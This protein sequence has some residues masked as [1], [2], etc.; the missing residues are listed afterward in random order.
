MVRIWKVWGSLENVARAK[1]EIF[2]GLNPDGTAIIFADDPR[3]EILIQR[4]NQNTNIAKV[5]LFGTQPKSDVLLSEISFTDHG[6]AFSLTMNGHTRQYT[7]PSP[8]GFH[9]L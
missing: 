3:R 9:G 8:R 2:E 6:I 5:M 1:A 4:A 7:V